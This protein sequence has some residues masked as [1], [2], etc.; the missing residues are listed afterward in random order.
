M[1]TLPPPAT[2]APPP[3][4]PAASR[5]VP[6]REAFDILGKWADA[7]PQDS[8]HEKIVGELEELADPNVWDDLSRV[9]EV[10][11]R[12]N[13]L[14]TSINA[15]V[16]TAP[17]V[18]NTSSTTTP[19][20]A[21]PAPIPPARTTIPPTQP[22][23]AASWLTAWAA[24]AAWQR[25]AIAGAVTTGL[26]AAAAVGAAA[27]LAAIGLAAIGGLGGIAAA[28]AVGAVRR[29]GVA[30][31]TGGA[32]LVVAAAVAASLLAGG[33]IRV[34]AAGLTALLAGAGLAALL[35][36]GQEIIAAMRIAADKD[37]SQ[38]PQR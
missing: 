24:W 10:A 35:A 2:G 20:P 12:L 9:E 33:H 7:H 36:G 19:A 6:T 8:N 25:L 26:L 23:P 18:P 34:T 29:G 4:Q 1:S 13:A 38:R 28:S 31:L 32:V 27:G 22:A 17:T 5:V 37:G 21:Q 3:A 14:L 16:W 30:G 11:G 15:G